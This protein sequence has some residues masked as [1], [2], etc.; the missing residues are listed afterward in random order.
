MNR[1][2]SLLK[3]SLPPR[4]PQPGTDKGT[5]AQRFYSENW[6]TALRTLPADIDAEQAARTCV[7][8]ASD[9]MDQV[10]VLLEAQ[11]AV[12]HAAWAL[13]RDK[14]QAEP[15]TMAL[16]LALMH[17]GYDLSYERYLPKNI[18]DQLKGRQ[19]EA[20]ESL[21]RKQ[22][23]YLDQ[24][25]FEGA[26]VGVAYERTEGWPHLSLNPAY[27][28]E[29]RN[30]T[31]KHGYLPQNL[32]ESL[33]YQEGKLVCRHFAEALKDPRTVKES[34]KLLAKGDATWVTAEDVR[35]ANMREFEPALS[36][37]QFSRAHLGKILNIL[38]QRLKAGEGRSFLLSYKVNNAATAEE[39]HTMRVY[40]DKP[41]GSELVWAALH[42][43]NLSADRMHKEALPEKLRQY[44]FDRFDALNTCKDAAV[45]SIDVEDRV[46]AEQLAGIYVENKDRHLAYAEAMACGNVVGMK[47]LVHSATSDAEPPTLIPKD[48]LS[49]GLS[50]AMNY[51][52]ADAIQCLG[53]NHTPEALRGIVLEK[54]PFFAPGVASAM[55]FGH[56]DAIKAWGKLLKQCTLEPEALAGILLAKDKYGLP[57]LHMALQ[58]GR[59]DSI[60]AF[61]DVLQKSQLG[62]SALKEILLAKDPEGVPGLISALKNHQADAVC[63]YAELV[64]NL[65]QNPTTQ[66]RGEDAKELRHLMRIAQDP[67]LSHPPQVSGLLQHAEALLADPPYGR[68]MDDTA[69]P[70]GPKSASKVWT[71]AL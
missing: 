57:A 28:P 63:A 39:G 70:Y 59:S 55:L 43:I 33:T 66:L 29:N 47:A 48:C 37:V 69:M 3:P 18:K 56:L 58:L 5:L 34:L 11:P 14:S 7:E 25:P 51:G 49:R 44:D 16:A 41:L 65:Q 19:E 62:A 2:P 71:S 10:S 50:L 21:R 38:M 60:K 46:L 52:H 67:R 26:R 12:A 54:E 64:I 1:I 30:G 24:L 17:A 31:L 36:S 35:R 4:V 9:R 20:S 6:R 8:F 15:L 40:I 68:T 42:E 45:L 53:E 61:G 27:S 32:F 22:Q 23:K 13:V